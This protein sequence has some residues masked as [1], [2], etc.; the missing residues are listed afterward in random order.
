MSVMVREEMSVLFTTSSPWDR[1]ASPSSRPMLDSAQLIVDRIRYLCSV[2]RP[3]WTTHIRSA[4]RNGI[5]SL[6][7]VFTETLVAD[8]REKVA[9]GVDVKIIDRVSEWLMTAIAH[10]MEDLIPK[11]LSSLED[12]IGTIFTKSE[13][14]TTVDNAAQGF[15][16]EQISN[17][18][19]GGTQQ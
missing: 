4:L 11:E 12:K 16:L 17:S 9:D 5:R 10:L 13:I 3:L 18:G 15:G 2:L 8:V 19:D 1:H 6:C 7:D 14:Q